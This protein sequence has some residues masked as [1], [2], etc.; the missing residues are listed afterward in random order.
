MSNTR[1]NKDSLWTVTSPK[2]VLEIG[3]RHNEV[4]GMGNLAIK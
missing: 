1:F 4:E 2:K 3:V